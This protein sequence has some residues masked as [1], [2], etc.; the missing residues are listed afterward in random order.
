MIAIERVIDAI[1]REL[2]LDPLD[3]RKAQSL[4]RRLRHVTPYG[5]T[6]E[7]NETL[8][9]IDRRARGARATIARAARAIAAFNATSPILKRGIALTP[10]KFGISFTLIHAQPG[11]RAGAC[12]HRRLDPSEPRRHRDGAG[13][14]HQG[15][16][17]RRRGVRRAARTS[18]ASPRPTPPRCR[19]PRRPP[20]R[21]APTS[22][23]W[24]RRSPRRRSSARMAAFAAEHW[25]VAPRD[26]RVPRRP[27]LRRQRTR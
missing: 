24:R 22:T 9:A 5:Q 2:G 6:V 1:A 11:R 12:L 10:V 26:G 19:T 8:P 16:A 21:P 4:R 3:V 17:G 25:G 20:P 27:R 13:P 23:A 14:V 7:D 15:R 18:C